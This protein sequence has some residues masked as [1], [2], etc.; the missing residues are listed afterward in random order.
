[1]TVELHHDLNAADQEALSALIQ[2]ENIP[3]LSMP[4]WLRVVEDAY[5]RKGAIFLSRDEDGTLNGFCIGYYTQNTYH[6][7]PF[8]FYVKKPALESQFFEALENFARE[9]Q[10]GQISVYSAQKYTALN[11][12]QARHHLALPLEAE[13]EDALYAAIPKK[14][15]NMIKKAQGVGFEISALWEHFEA[16]YEIYAAHCRTKNLLQKPKAYFETLKCVFGDAIVLL[17]AL[18]AGKPVAGMIFLKD[19]SAASYLFNA[20]TGEAQK[21][22]VNNLLMWEASKA[23]YQEGIELIELGLSAQ[24]SPVYKFKKRLSKNIEELSI[25]SYEMRL[26]EKNKLGRFVMNKYNGLMSRLAM[27]KLMI[28]DQ[29]KRLF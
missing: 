27:H 2:A 25:Y 12:L 29:E 24:E 5:S 23:F 14:Q 6:T 21:A 28:E 8:G 22:G 20:S 11:A 18:K 1:M 17:C 9:N 10:L 4:S 15:R 3:P 16:F 26:E 7:T 19:E 13:S